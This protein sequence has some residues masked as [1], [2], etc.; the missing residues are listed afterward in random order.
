MSEVA[1]RR[2][3]SGFYFITDSKLTVHGVIEDVRRALAA[4]VALVQYREKE[5]ASGERRAEAEEMLALCRGSDV[6]H[7]GS[8]VAHTG[9]SVPLIVNDDIRLARDIGAQG[10]HLGQDDAPPSEARRELGPG[11]IIGVSVGNCKEARLAEEAGA[12]YLAVSPVF[13]TP[14]KPDAGPAVGVEGVRAIRAATDLP[15]VAIGG[16]TLE[17][18]PPVVEAGADLVCAIS[19]SLAGGRV[20][21]NIANLKEAMRGI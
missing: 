10:V 20:A 21:E 4:G 6:A 19:V 18:I 2:R 17:N 11:A 13:P 5:R 12:D 16:L 1:P 7:T 8:G 9:S 15:L 3:W 14:T